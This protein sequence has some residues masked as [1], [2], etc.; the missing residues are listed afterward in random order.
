MK[1]KWKHHMQFTVDEAALS[2]SNLHINYSV[3]V[4]RC[5]FRDCDLRGVNISIQEMLN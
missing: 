4:N 2:Q 1:P 5:C 3:G